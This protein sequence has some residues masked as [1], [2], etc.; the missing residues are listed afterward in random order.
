[1]LGLSLTPFHDL[2]D[3][4]D[5]GV[6]LL[7][8]GRRIRAVNPAYCALVGVSNEAVL[9]RDCFH[10]HKC[11]EYKLQG[12]PGQVCGKDLC[13]EAC[14]FRHPH[15]SISSRLIWLEVFG[16]ADLPCVQSYVSLSKEGPEEGGLLIFLVPLG[17][18]HE[19]VLDSRRLKH[20]LQLA[21]QVQEVLEPARLISTSKL[22]LGVRCRSYRP[23]G[24]DL[25]ETWVTL[26]G[27][28]AVLYVADISGKS[29]P[30]ALLAPGVRQRAHQNLK[31]DLRR[32]VQTLNLKL[33]D[34]LPESMFVAATLVRHHLESDEFVIV[35]AGGPE[36]WVYRAE[37][38]A[39]PLERCLGMA[40]GIQERVQYRQT[41]V[42]LS[43][44]D[45]LLLWTDGIT[46]A[47]DRQGR[48]PRAFIKELGQAASGRL[49]ERLDALLADL[50]TEDDAT[51]MA[52]RK[53]SSPPIPVT[54]G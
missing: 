1:M 21:A 38:R 8:S 30:A 45:L 32:S 22:E 5:I 10:T 50:P 43:E 24:G 47:L 49:Q 28:E 34:W 44:G 23:V 37:G 16:G 2:F 18:L 46:E 12:Q 6:V 26:S 35:N 13:Q 41:S 3:R 7:D 51:V 14:P 42:R 53:T 54:K 27:Q 36:P 17:G 19:M 20:E 11:M 29:L 9:A 4:L 52:V 33:H 31:G 48:G 39:R 25:Y 40:L 15:S